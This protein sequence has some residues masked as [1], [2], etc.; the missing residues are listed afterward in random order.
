MSTACMPA[1][2]S[3]VGAS[4][5]QSANRRG[6][7]ALDFLSKNLS[8]HFDEE[9]QKVEEEGESRARGWEEADDEQTEVQTLPDS[10]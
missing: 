4:N 6:A 8:H 10:Q 9:E 3:E 7:K 1:I 5:A 2:R